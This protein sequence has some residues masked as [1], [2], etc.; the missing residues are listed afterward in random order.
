MSQ[1]LLMNIS[2]RLLI[3][4]P[5][6]QPQ[7]QPH[8]TATATAMKQPKPRNLP[9]LTPPLCTVDLFQHFSISAF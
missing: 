8:N 5:N 6:P 2:Q 3:V 1:D 7:P 9:L 4:A